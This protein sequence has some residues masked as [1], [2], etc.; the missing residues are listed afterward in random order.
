MNLSIN[1]YSSPGKTDIAYCITIII[2]LRLLSNPG[3]GPYAT[4]FGFGNGAD[5]KNGYCS[6]DGRF[7]LE[8][9]G[10][11][12]NDYSIPS[13]YPLCALCCERNTI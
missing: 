11:V 5:V 10:R 8:V 13:S 1:P 2:A 7:Y 12:C 9:E 6:A 3:T 4:G